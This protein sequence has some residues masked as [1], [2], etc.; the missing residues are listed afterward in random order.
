M[1][2][3][4]IHTFVKNYQNTE[5]EKVRTSYGTLSSVTGIVCNILLFALKAIIGLMA[6]S[7][8][9]V[10]DGF[11]N[12]SDCM[13]CLIVLFGVKLSAQPADSEHPFGHGRIEYISS[14]VMAMIIFVVGWELLVASVKQIL[15]P[16]TVSFSWVMVIAL[17]AG[18]LVKLWMASFNTK[19]G[20]KIDNMA[21]IASAKDSRNDVLATSATLAAMILGMYFPKIPF[22]GIA[23]VFVALFIF[24]S[25]IGIAKD[26]VS[27]LIG[28]PASEDLVKRIRDQIL[29]HPEIRG[30]HD[31]IIHDY[32]RGVKIGSAHAE[33]DSHMDIM[34]AHDIIDQAEKE[35]GEKE[36]VMMT[37]H[38]DPIDFSD[39]ET[40]YYY[41]KVHAVIAGMSL[42]MHDFRMV[43]GP[44]HVNLVFD[45]LVPYDSPYSEEE[46][47]AKCD[48]AV[49][50]ESKP[51]YTV[52][53][54]DHG[55]TE[56][57]IKK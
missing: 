30:V 33:V 25:G 27:R 41:D 48:E 40:N 43:K 37:L 23:G 54:F 51:V 36:H 4:L 17:A 35:V 1:T 5:D 26:I 24:W 9:V 50:H 44:T 38:M 46:I 13:S 22:D 16:E 28:S 11:N 32:G 34:T 15:H 56:A 39:P 19:I 45:V 21:M 52:I 31:M 10:S 47:K 6:N 42:R 7:I 12:L 20:K 53:T 29:S 49:S 57:E 2:D 3:F 18:I 14:F 55:Y 8:A